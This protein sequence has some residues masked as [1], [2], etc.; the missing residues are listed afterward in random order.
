MADAQFR[1]H[2]E[3]TSELEH[4][5]R[6]RELVV[7]ALTERLEQAADQLDRLR[8]T[9][10]DRGPRT[11]GL[12]QQLVESQQSLLDDLQNAV[13]QWE[14]LQAASSLGRLETQLTEMRDLIISRFDRLQSDGV[15]AASREAAPRRNSAPEPV[16]QPKPARESA[17]DGKS[18]SAGNL[19]GW[20]AVKAMLLA[21]NP[22]EQLDR[23][24]SGGSEQ[25][26]GTTG[27]QHDSPPAGSEFIPPAGKPVQFP[28][29][30][31]L[32]QAERE[33]LAFAVL[34]RDE[35]IAALVRQLREA[36]M[37][38]CSTIDWQS[39]TD[40]P[41]ELTSEL[42][43]MQ[44]RLQQRLSEAEVELSLERARLAREEVRLK[45]LETQLRRQSKSLGLS[46]D[47]PAEGG[48]AADHPEKDRE[49][50]GKWMRLL[51][52]S[53]SSDS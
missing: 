52:R 37:Q 46:P 22:A 51:G 41:E 24:G 35:C 12:P 39:L 1:E 23:P 18:E 53:H 16:A 34:E 43:H 21:E 15:P 44:Q 6:E 7:A 28:E 14:D 36:D 25:E 5:L 33:E 47:E 40:A 19:A 13:Q 8:R 2:D 4:Q 42:Q 38:L 29:P 3:R 30:V 49:G 27:R 45:Q 9:G 10:A 50:S 17:A 26:R 31:D 11:A 20:D 32:D 48:T